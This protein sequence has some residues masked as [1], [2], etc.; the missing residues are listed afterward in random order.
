MS[1]IND[2]FN[3]SDEDIKRWEEISEQMQQTQEK[4]ERYYMLRL[5]HI[6]GKLLFSKDNNH[7]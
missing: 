3:W 5:I 1:N 6:V 2:L 7:E 4:L